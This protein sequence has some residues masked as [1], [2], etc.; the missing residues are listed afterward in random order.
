L[1]IEMTNY[2]GTKEFATMRSLMA[3]GYMVPGILGHWLAGLNCARTGSYHLAFLFTL[4][5]PLFPFP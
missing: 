1:Q 3:I 4:V 2:Y 5:S